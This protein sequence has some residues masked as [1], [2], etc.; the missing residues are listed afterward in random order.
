MKPVDSR[1]ADRLTSFQSRLAYE[2]LHFTAHTVAVNTALAQDRTTWA[3]LRQM[4]I[5]MLPQRLN[6]SLRSQAD[7]RSP[8]H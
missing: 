5:S 3:L 4:V 6:H 8:V 1:P 2:D 7:R